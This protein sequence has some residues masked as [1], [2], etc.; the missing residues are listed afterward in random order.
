MV[1]GCSYLSIHDSSA[2]GPGYRDMK[3]YVSILQHL[4][5][6]LIF[7]PGKGS[8]STSDLDRKS[9][10]NLGWV[11]SVVGTCRK[12]LGYVVEE[13]MLLRFGL[14]PIRQRMYYVD[15]TDVGSGIIYYV[16]RKMSFSECWV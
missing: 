4:S 8:C 13:N 3:I 14:C 15:C 11:E 9:F 10:G 1:S 16:G 12:C 6:L 2:G 7:T 5:F